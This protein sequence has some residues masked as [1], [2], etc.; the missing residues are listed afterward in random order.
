[1]TACLDEILEKF[2]VL[3]EDILYMVLTKYYN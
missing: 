2:Y 1:M 3:L